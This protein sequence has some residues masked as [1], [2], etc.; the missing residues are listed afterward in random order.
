MLRRLHTGR[1]D[2]QRSTIIPAPTVLAPDLAAS[3]PG[4]R[5]PR[6]EQTQTRAQVELEMGLRSLMALKRRLILQNVGNG[7]T[8]GTG[9]LPQK[10]YETN[11]TLQVLQSD[12]MSQRTV[13]CRDDTLGPIL[14]YSMAAKSFHGYYGLA[15]DARLIFRVFGLWTLRFVNLHTQSQTTVCAQYIPWNHDLWPRRR[16]VI[17]AQASHLHIRL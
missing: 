14:R 17:I 12:L 5:P 15:S 3:R 6:Q 1:N 11:Q 8:P 16:G 2:T 9:L 4:G 13:V 10:G 7:L